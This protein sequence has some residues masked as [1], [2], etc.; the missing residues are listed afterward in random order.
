[1]I[2]WSN[3]L[4]FFA[5]LWSFRS[6]PPRPRG[7]ACMYFLYSL[8]LQ[9][10]HK[11]L[12][13]GSPKFG[14]RRSKIDLFLS[15]TKTPYVFFCKSWKVILLRSLASSVCKDSGAGKCFRTHKTQ[16]NPTYCITIYNKEIATNFIATG[17][18]RINSTE[19]TMC[20]ILCTWY[21]VL[22]LREFLT[23]HETN[24]VPQ[25]PYSPNLAPADLFFA[26]E[27]KILSKRSP[28]SDGGGDRRKSDKGPSCHPAKHV[29][30][31]VPELEKTLDAVYQGWRGVHWG[32]QVWLSCK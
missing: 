11:R 28:I 13:A 6:F 27:V 10:L 14:R 17:C 7:L 4:F 3:N 26:P 8:W 29:P 12:P 24:V 30:G 20:Y 21:T 32:R 25:P 22:F 18:K 23:K 2:H 19:W 15:V 5:I 31:R 16:P 1:M 9:L